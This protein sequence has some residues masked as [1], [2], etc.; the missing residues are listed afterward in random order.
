MVPTAGPG[1]QVVA[2]PGPGP[3]VA[4]PTKPSPMIVLSPTDEPSPA[5]GMAAMTGTLVA[6]AVPGPIPA[7][8]PAAY[9]VGP[10]PIPALYGPNPYPVGPSTVPA[11]P[12][13]PTAVVYSPT[14]YAG[15]PSWSCDRSWLESGVAPPRQRLAQRLT[16]T[17]TS[18]ARNISRGFVETFWESRTTA[19]YDAFTCPTSLAQIVDETAFGYSL[20]D[21]PV[22]T[23]DLKVL[24]ADIINIEQAE[25][26]GNGNCGDM[27]ISCGVYVCGLRYFENAPG[28]TERFEQ[29]K[30]EIK[31]MQRKGAIVKLTFLFVPDRMKSKT[32][33]FVHRAVGNMIQSAL[34]L[35]VD[36]IDIRAMPGTASEV[37]MVVPESV[38]T[39]TQLYFFD[40][41]RAR[42]PVDMMLT[43]NFEADIL[44]FPLKDIIKYGHPYL[45]YIT[46][47]RANRDVME[48]AI[49]NGVPRSKLSWG[50]PIGCVPEEHEGKNYKLEDSIRTAELARDELYAGVSHWSIQRD[51]NHRT[52]DPAL[53]ACNGEQTGMPDGFYLVNMASVMNE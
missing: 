24:G 30:V 44:G 21:I 25:L 3:T 35:G 2:N 48:Q 49:A 5:L 52:T 38:A 6:D 36:G 23:P 34:L 33:D 10:S 19:P 39:A 41:L 40:N 43:Y 8:S 31:E 45:D 22:T 20:T 13:N 14:Q 11:P 1:L 50:V 16:A 18:E 4:I 7:A 9:H 42:M 26:D 12:P 37:G 15:Q 29:L 47:N 46:G 27:A 32:T 51:T 28:D 17:G 53:P